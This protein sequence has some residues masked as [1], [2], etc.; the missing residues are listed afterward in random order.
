MRIEDALKR[1]RE[2]YTAAHLSFHQE[3]VR[4][5]PSCLQE[6]HQIQYKRS[7]RAFKANPCW[8]TL[9]DLAVSIGRL[10]YWIS[11]SCTLP[12]AQSLSCLQED[13]EGEF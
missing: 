9:R 10:G 2:F 7:L 13:F 12:Y 3:E 4:N 5:A 11:L 8:G 1:E 6:F